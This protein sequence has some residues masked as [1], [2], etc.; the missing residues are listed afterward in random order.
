M[1]VF[2][3]PRYWADVDLAKRIDIELE[4]HLSTSGMRESG[5][6]PVRIVTTNFKYAYWSFA[7]MITHHTSNGCNLQ[8]G[9]LLA[10]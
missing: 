5:E 7:Q 9:D 2:A 8:P 4:A 1:L 6:A 3:S 10:R